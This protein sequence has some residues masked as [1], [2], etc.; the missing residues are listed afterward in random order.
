MAIS[1]SDRVEIHVVNDYLA[2]R[3]SPFIQSYDERVSGIL[4]WLSRKSYHSVKL[5]QL[6][7]SYGPAPTHESADAIIATPETLGNCHEI[8]RMRKLSNL[9]ELSIL[10]VPHLLDYSGKII[11][12]S[13]I[14]SG[15]IDIDGNAWID[16]SSRQHK[17]KMV[18]QLDKELKTP[19][20][21]LFEGPEEYPEVAMAEA[22]ESI[23]RE[24]SS[25]VAVGDV[26]V[27]TLIG[28]GVVPDIGIVDGMTKRT[29]L[30]ESEIIDGSEFTNILRATNPAG[31]LTPSLINAVE[32]A[33]SN[34]ESCLIQVEGEEDLAPIIIHC[35]APIGTAVI[36]GQPKVGVVVQMSS[37]K[38][39]N[40][41]R[42]ILSSFEV[43]G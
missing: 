23:G 27:A 17:L 33:L 32:E 8:N 14:R 7:D 9:T 28:M 21:D 42:D 15:R 30:E 12:S 41:C 10:E 26:S 38:I 11:S 25:I 37:L 3:K 24:N 43:V 36:Y 18:S 20:G 1:R 5:F 40:R 29:K 4:D 2:S 6:H 34:D 39:K 19:M 31:H 13:R 16:A 22:L 35:L